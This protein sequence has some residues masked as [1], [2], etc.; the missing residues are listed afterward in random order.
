M[1]FLN[2]FHRYQNQMKNNKVIIVTLIFAIGKKVGI[3]PQTIIIT[4]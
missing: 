3:E 2:V 4:E 1:C